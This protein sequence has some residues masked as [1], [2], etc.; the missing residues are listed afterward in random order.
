MVTFMEFGIM[1][2]LGKMVFFVEVVLLDVFVVLMEAGS[3][4]GML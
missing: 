4:H 3:V 2:W 1:V